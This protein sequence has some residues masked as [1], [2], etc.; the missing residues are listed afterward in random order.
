MGFNSGFKGL[1]AWKGTSLP[2][3]L[4]SADSPTHHNYTELCNKGAVILWCSFVF[5]CFWS[6]SPPVGHGLLI[7]EVF[8]ITHND[9]PQSVGFLWTSDQPDA[10]TSTWQHSQQTNFHAPGGIRTHDLSR[11][12]A[13]DIRLRPRGHWG[14]PFCDVGLELLKV[15]YVCP[16][17]TASS[18]KDPEVLY[19]KKWKQ[20]HYRPGQALRVPGDWG[21]RISRQ[22]AHEGGKVVSPTHRPPLPPRICTL[23]ELKNTSGWLTVNY[24]DRSFN[25]VWRYTCFFVVIHPDVL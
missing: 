23:Y 12:A 4:L 21:S 24:K 1:S 8:Y 7:H 9:A 17:G 16:N 13:A 2:L 5:V 18:N 10:E 19:D 22:S 3:P 14:R 6:D 11:R 20:S 25:S 15:N